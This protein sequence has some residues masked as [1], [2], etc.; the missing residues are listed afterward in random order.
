M[1]AAAGSGGSDKSDEKKVD[2]YSQ[3]YQT[4]IQKKNKTGRYKNNSKIP[5][6]VGAVT[7]ALKDP[8]DRYNLNK[9]M[10]FANKEGV[11]IN[12]QGLS[13]DEILSKDFKSQLDAK[14]YSKEPG[15][16][17]GN[18]NRGDNNNQVP[19]VATT[20]PTG[21]PTTVELSQSSA[22]DAAA[23]EPIDNLQT[24]KKKAKAK[25]RSMT[26]LTSSKGIK[27][28]EGLTLG[29]KSLLGS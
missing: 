4:L 19:P 11:N 27:S 18:D 6:V 14:G 8:I 25:G 9:R 22:A 13:T 17:G 26:I 10:K 28:D 2:T 16:V 23:I 20:M 5:S 3:Q 24:R 7:T 15:N 21:T 12:L 1:G 29:K